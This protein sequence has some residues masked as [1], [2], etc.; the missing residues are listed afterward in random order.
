MAGPPS[1]FT[2]AGELCKLH[3]HARFRIPSPEPC[4]DPRAGRDADP[5]RPARGMGPPRLGGP[6]RGLPRAR[7]HGGGGLLRLAAFARPAR[8]PA[9]T[10]GTRAPLVAAPARAR[11]RRRRVAGVAARGLA[12]SPRATR[13][14]DPPRSVGA[15]RLCG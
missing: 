2:H 6:P 15:A 10:T 1:L 7:T 3:G 11:R 8:A 14:A 9:R 4:H 13:R 5:R 12:R